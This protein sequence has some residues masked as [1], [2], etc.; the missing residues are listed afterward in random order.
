MGNLLGTPLSSESEPESDFTEDETGGYVDDKENVA[1]EQTQ[2]HDDPASLTNHDARNSSELTNHDA[3]NSPELTN[4]ELAL[5]KRTSSSE[6]EEENDFIPACS[7][8]E[9]DH[10]S[11]DI[12]EENLSSPVSDVDVKI[13]LRDEDV[14]AGVQKFRGELEAETREQDQERDSGCDPECESPNNNTSNNNGT[15][16]TPAP[17]IEDM[18]EAVLRDLIGG[19]VTMVTTS[20][21]CPADLSQAGQRSPQRWESWEV[22]MSSWVKNKVNRK[23]KREK[24]RDG[25]LG[26]STE[27]EQSVWSKAVGYVQNASEP[28]NRQQEKKED[29]KKGYSAV[30]TDVTPEQMAL[31]KVLDLRRW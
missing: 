21:S 4:G 28:D 2:P 11:K 29:E 30:T 7:R 24:P 18:V 25:L 8:S 5:S 26:Q 15:I 9:A 22:D 14:F 16:L 6:D 17:P 23:V 20:Q 27:E 10:T 31:R 12:F 1:F 19:A 3:H 13:E